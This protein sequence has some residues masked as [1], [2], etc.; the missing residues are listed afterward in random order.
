VQRYVVE[1]TPEYI[2]Y[3][4]APTE[5]VQLLAV[6]ASPWNIQDIWE[7]TAAVQ[8][9]AIISNAA[10]MVEIRSDIDRAI[11][12]DG[13]VKQSIIRYML[14]LIKDSYKERAVRY[15]NILEYYDVKWPDLDVIRDTVTSMPD[16]DY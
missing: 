13:K 7:P 12:N 1:E 8:K 10:T 14:K 9:L 6:S 5:E 16:D 11:F 4:N 3:I 15:M 2:R